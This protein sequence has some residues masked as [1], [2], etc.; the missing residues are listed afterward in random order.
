[1]AAK[2]VLAFAALI[3]LASACSVAPGGCTKRICNKLA[4]LSQSDW[5]K[6]ELVGFHRGR[7][8]SAVPKSKEW[9]KGGP[10]VNY[11]IFTAIG[12]DGSKGVIGTSKVKNLGECCAVC[13]QTSGCKL[14]QFFEKG[15]VSSGKTGV[16]GFKEGIQCYLLNNGGEAIPGQSFGT[17]VSG[18]FSKQSE[19]G[20]TYDGSWVGGICN[21]S[22]SVKDD[23]HFTGAMGTSFDFNGELNKPFCLITDQDFHLNVLLK[24]YEDSTAEKGMRS[25]IKELGLLWN[26]NGQTHTA[27]LAARNGK[28]QERG[29][30]FLSAVEIDNSAVA[31]PASEGEAAKADGFTLTFLGVEKLGPYDVDRYALDIAGVAKLTLRLRVAHQKLQ[32]PDDAEAHFNIEV[33]ELKQTPKVHGVLGQTFRTTEDQVKRALKYSELVELLHTPVRADGAT[34]QGFLDGS[35]KDYETSSVLASDCGFAAFSQ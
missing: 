30:G 28:Q 10:I 11:E 34:G 22:G 17:P 29:N 16:P 12:L 4:K 20:K 26:A 5:N 8:T 24:G 19:T 27:R 14:Y 3:S 23:P 18:T 32:S 7:W 21:P 25:W 1:M 31:V 15:S 6:S 9:K 35:V 33:V 2:V 13:A